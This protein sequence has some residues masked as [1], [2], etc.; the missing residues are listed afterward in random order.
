[1]IHS[2][3]QGLIFFRHSYLD[4]ST[5]RK[6]VIIESDDWGS[7]RMPSY[8]VY[9]KLLKRGFA[10]YQRPFEK[11]DSIATNQDFEHLVDTIS[12]YR[13]I[14]GNHPIITANVITANPDFKKIKENNFEK[15]YYESFKTT[16]EKYDQISFDSWKYAIREKVFFPQ[17]HGREHLNVSTWMESL[18]DIKSDNRI[19]FNFEMMGVPTKVNPDL[20]NQHQIAFNLDFSK[21][22][23]R[24]FVR[25]S[26]IE[27]QQIFES[28]FGFLSKTFISPVYTWNNYI[29][30]CL[31]EVAIDALQGGRYQI[32]PFNAKKKKHYIGEISKN[33]N[34]LYLVR[35][36]FF[37]PS[38]VLDYDQRFL[39]LNQLKRQSDLAFK[40]KKPL[41]ISM[42]RL[43]FIGRIFERNRI[44]NLCLLD[45]YLKWLISNYPDVEFITSVELVQL[46]KNN[47]V[48]HT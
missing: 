36:A 16:I 37:E 29:E 18:M 17:L 1:M 40:F 12:K 15:Y 14:N 44:V 13:D 47:E 2:I 45:D 11:F 35:N 28:T 21:M 20:G 43:N 23:N 5:D 39:Q 48:S 30:D 9:E 25:K 26:I 19:A 6:L 41:V 27:A 7:I 10:I 8:E 46:I 34:L 38:T 22:E 42:H 33:T 32:I 24:E 3:I 4:W 31:R